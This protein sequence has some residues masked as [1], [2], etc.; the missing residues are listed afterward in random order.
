[1]LAVHCHTDR[2]G[3]ISKTFDGSAWFDQASVEDI[4][5]FLDG[6]RWQ[7][8]LSSSFAALDFLEFYKDDRLAEIDARLT[9]DADHDINVLFDVDAEQGMAWFEANRPDVFEELSRT[10]QRAYSFA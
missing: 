2:R 10:S 7:G 1:M 8:N 3:S 9:K 6:D 4:V 5:A